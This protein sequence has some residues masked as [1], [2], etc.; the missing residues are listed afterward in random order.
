MFSDFSSNDFQKPQLYEMGDSFEPCL[1]DNHQQSLTPIEEEYTDDISMSWFKNSS[2]NT[3]IARDADSFLEDLFEDRNVIQAVS[4]STE[5]YSESLSMGEDQFEVLDLPKPQL[6][7]K[8]KAISKEKSSIKSNSTKSKAKL[9]KKKTTQKLKKLF[10]HTSPI[11][12]DEFSGEET[13]SEE[14]INP[15]AKCF[16][17][18]YKKR[19]LKSSCLKDNRALLNYPLMG[20]L[21]NFPAA[22]SR[23]SIFKKANEDPL[24]DTDCFINDSLIRYTNQEMREANLI[25]NAL[26]NVIRSQERT[27]E[28]SDSLH[29]INAIIAKLQAL[30]EKF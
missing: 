18:E 24:S 5:A 13:D 3:T 20:D 21:S 29:G 7:K 19:E 4:T 27:S 14:V 8:S 12:I 30:K 1:W 10:K 17:L 2:V 6:S 11:S 25:V 28:A 15:E 22:F 16:D 9:S 23:E 26:G